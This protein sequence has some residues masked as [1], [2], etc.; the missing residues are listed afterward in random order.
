M[1]NGKQDNSRKNREKTEKNS[2]AISAVFFEHATNSKETRWRGVPLVVERKFVG[3][4]DERDGFFG[5][6]GCL[7]ARKAKKEEFFENSSQ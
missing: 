2:E 4:Y 3:N 6:N 1:Y 5:L 7:L